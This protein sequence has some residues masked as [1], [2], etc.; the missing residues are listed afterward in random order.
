MKRKD[1]S[2]DDYRRRD[3]ERKRSARARAAR[4]R[5]ARNRELLSASGLPME[6]IDEVTGSLDGDY[7]VKYYRK[8]R[9][10]AICKKPC[11]YE[12]RS[13]GRRASIERFR[14][15]KRR[16]GEEYR[17]AVRRGYWEAERAKETAEA[18]KSTLYLYI[19]SRLMRGGEGEG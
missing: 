5:D 15:V 4:E 3:A 8:N 9:S 10:L 12:V 19:V 17:D 18:R 14:E 1:E 2:W 7:Y 16:A 13:A 6:V 11:E